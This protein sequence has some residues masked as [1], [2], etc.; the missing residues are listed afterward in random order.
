MKAPMTKSA[1]PCASRI[2]AALRRTHRSLP[3]LWMKRLSICAGI[4]PPARSWRR[5]SSSRAMSSG[6]VILRNDWPSIS[7]RVWPTISQNARFTWRKTPS[8]VITTRPT[9]VWSKTWRTRSKSRRAGSLASVLMGLAQTG[10]RAPERLR[11][12]A[13]E[14]L[15]EARAEALGELLEVVLLLSV[16][17]HA[18]GLDHLARDEFEIAE[19]I[20]EAELHALLSGPHQSR[21]RLRCFLQPLPAPLAHDAD[22]LLVDLADHLLRVLAVRRVLGHERIE[23]VLVLAGGVGAPLD[24]ELFHGAGEAE[25]ADDDAD[26]ADEARLVDVDPFGRHRDVVAAGGAQVLHH[27]VD[28]RVRVLGAQAPDLVVDVARLDGAAAG[29]VDAQHHALRVGVLEGAVQSLD[30]LLRGGLRIGSD[31]A[32]HLDQRGVAAHAGTHAVAIGASDPAEPGGEDEEYDQEPEE[33][34]QCAPLARPALFIEGL[35]RDSLEHGALPAGG[36]RIRHFASAELVAFGGALSSR[37]RTS[38]FLSRTCSGSSEAPRHGPATQNPVLG[39]KIAPCVEQTK[40]SPL[41]SKNSPGCQSSS[42]PRCGQRFTNAHTFPEWRTAKPLSPAAS[43]GNSKR[44][45]FP[46]SGSAAEAQISRSPSAIDE[47]PPRSRS[48]PC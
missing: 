16:V 22:E 5:C 37:R 35:E 25:A 46:P 32:L 44:T 10:C 45:P 31:D 48:S 28:R 36:D 47:A 7:S 23:E 6:W 12:G 3:D 29:A 21:K 15:A 2:T 39:S 34:E 18:L 1:A 33:L 9:A 27:R 30:D 4:S 42:V 17:D 24:A 43:P 13:P 40:Y 41:S 8:G 19:R 38:P 20:G 26:G 11:R 14:R